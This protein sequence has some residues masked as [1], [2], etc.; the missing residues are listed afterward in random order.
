MALSRRAVLAAPAALLPAAAAAATTLKVV[1]SISIIADL[2]RQIGGAR[3]AVTALIGPEQDP[4]GFQARPSDAQAI[5]TADLMVINGLGL[6]SWAER[7]AAS[8]GYRKPGVVASRGVRPL[9][10][11]EAHH[12]SGGGHAHDHGAYDP[13]AWQDVANVKLYTA[14]I[15][16]GLAAADPAGATAYA[17]SA[18]AYLD[19]LDRL[20]LDIRAA[21][22]PIPRNRRK[23]VTSHD[24]F[25][26][27]GDAYDVDFLAPQGLSTEGEPSAR[28]FA[29]LIAQVRAEGIRALFIENISR[30]T[31]LE[32]VARETGVRVG[33]TLYSDA[34]SRADGPAATYEA[35]MRHNTRLIAGALG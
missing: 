2:V 33:G 10:G 34:L 9:L 28:D 5:A 30:A 25:L 29:A 20:D 7:L 32:Q 31:L 8:A 21:F 17:A 1:A 15:R 16:D 19:R 23:I 6:E 22:L 3:L 11:G 4:H 13:H 24:A 18:A 27:Y 12:G 26:Y 35:M 14:N